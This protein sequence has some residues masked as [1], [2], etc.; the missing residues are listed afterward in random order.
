MVTY[1]DESQSEAEKNKYVYNRVGDFPIVQLRKQE[2]K[3]NL[4]RSTSVRIAPPSRTVM[5]RDVRSA[6][7]RSN[8]F[9]LGPNVPKLLPTKMRA[10]DDSHQIITNHEPLPLSHESV[11]SA[12]SVLDAL[13]KNCRK[14]ISNEELT[15]DRNKRMCAPNTPLEVVDGRE[16]API[17]QQSA[18][19]NRDQVSPSKTGLGDSPFS[20]LRKRSK[21]R[22]NALLSSLSS[23]NFVLKPYTALPSSSFAA[24]AKDPT[25]STTTTTSQ[26]QLAINVEQSEK[27]MKEVS[28]TAE[29]KVDDVIHKPEPRKLYLFNRKIEAPVRRTHRADIDNDDDDDEIKINFIKPRETASS[30]GIDIV[31]HVE[32]DKLSKMLTGLSGGFSS[33]S[34]TKTD[35]KDSVDAPQ[36]SIS[37]TTSTFS[38]SSLPITTPVSAAISSTL[39][40]STKPEVKTVETEKVTA[41]VD[42]TKGGKT[43]TPIETLSFPFAATTTSSSALP[44]FGVAT[45]TTAV[46]SASGVASEKVSPLTM[47]S[48]PN[49]NSKAS[50]NAAVDSN[51]SLISFTPVAKATEGTAATASAVLI[52]SAIPKATIAPSLSIN[53][54]GFSLS[55]SATDPAKPSGGFSF[56]G[57]SSGISFPSANNP[58]VS[59]VPTG[60]PINT[61]TLASAAVPSSL[62]QTP[63]SNAFSFGAKP[64][65]PKAATGIVSPMSSGIPGISSLTGHSGNLTSTTSFIQKPATTTAS[66]IGFSFTSSA[67]P[68]PS[69]PTVTTA[70]SGFSFGS[71]QNTM[72]SSTL[73][74]PVTTANSSFNFGS[75]S[76]SGFGA[77]VAAS[78]GFVQPSATSG[79]GQPAAASTGFG[80]SNST[81]AFGAAP[82]ATSSGFG[83]SAGTTPMF[84][85]NSTTTTTTAGG[86]PALSSTA[87]FSFGQ[88]STNQASGFP[89]T[90]QKSE[91]AVSSNMFSFGQ[92]QNA[93]VAP[94][95]SANTSFPFGG[96]AVQPAPATSAFSFGQN[97]STQ[98][99]SAASPAA[100]IF[101]R[102]GDKPAE[103][104][105]AFSFGGSAQPQQPI[106][107][108]SNNPSAQPAAPLFG[109]STNPGFGQPSVGGANMFGGTPSNNQSS[110]FGGNAKSPGGNMFA[111]GNS[112]NNNPQQPN[113]PAPAGMFSFGN[114]NNPPSNNAPSG[115]FGGN[116]GQNV[117]ASFTFKPSTGVVTNNSAP[118]AFGQSSAGPP[119]AYQFGQTTSNNASASF[120]F[121]PNQNANSAPTAP[122][123]SFNFGAPQSA[124]VT[125]GSFN[126]Q[127]QQPILTPQPSPG[128]GLFSIGTGGNPQRRPIRQAMRRMK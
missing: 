62:L 84:G 1:Y 52:T 95:S 104:K 93:S 10:K 99:A 80:P 110:D 106:F 107:G 22:N 33:T 79:F 67:A 73:N 112:T 41:A 108:G 8:S 83:N 23:S 125:G 111:F 120:T 113:Q 118:N 59:S 128:G 74:A 19:R 2:L 34:P 35:Q 122:T 4:V 42:G 14:R 48:T 91:S 105:P 97:N 40:V 94:N 87:S 26:P 70:S 43:E 123:S 90:L 18:K 37:F 86:F 65:S 47:F 85:G 30:N 6:I 119:P 61:P 72:G 51:K 60:A 17:V 28:I 121:A 81:P 102:L 49:N 126:F 78:T 55:Q 98:Q 89:N 13:E 101:G 69:I 31:R 54:G 115:V 3:R 7:L 58:V 117:S 45:T 39:S 64:T 68:K 29:K 5:N 71:S 127:G 27:Q 109:Q 88:Q 56:G 124:P 63:S 96:G 21:I 12:K 44:T 82:S 92:N 53:A 25:F 20:Q 24:F 116:Q 76:T 11:Q 103:A 77:P 57:T 100:G 9:H 15:L 50:S 38:V 46:S 114:S 66:G 16:F 36:A 75:S 32:K